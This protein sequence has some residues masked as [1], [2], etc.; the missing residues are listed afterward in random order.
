MDFKEAGFS[1]VQE[2]LCNQFCS[3]DQLPFA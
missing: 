1:G 2:K 3:V